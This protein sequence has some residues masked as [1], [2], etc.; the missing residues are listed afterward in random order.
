MPRKFIKWVVIL[1]CLDE[2]DECETLRELQHYLYWLVPRYRDL[3]RDSQKS[4]K[5][6]TLMFEAY[7][8]LHN[9]LQPY[10]FN[11]KKTWSNGEK[12]IVKK[13]LTD[14]FNPLVM[15]DVVVKVGRTPFSIYEI[16]FHTMWENVRRGNRS[17]LKRAVK[18]AVRYGFARK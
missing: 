11:Y 6:R 17:L 8:D 7:N 2:I 15:A 10:C 16:Y 1:V 14:P 5:Y 9:I 3:E 18:S 12:E 4:G 13:Y